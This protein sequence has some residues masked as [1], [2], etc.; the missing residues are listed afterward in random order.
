MKGN[1]IHRLHN[2]D[3]LFKF[4]CVE[5]K[6]VP[7]TLCS[8]AATTLD[9]QSPPCLSLL[10]LD[11]L[12]QHRLRRRVVLDLNATDLIEN[13]SCCLSLPFGS[14]PSSS[15]RGHQEQT[16]SRIALPSWWTGA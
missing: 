11:L 7:F 6:V 10:Q 5:F 14:S 15:H 13:L 1:D 3:G 9:T 12:H 4:S 16:L 2:S 8:V